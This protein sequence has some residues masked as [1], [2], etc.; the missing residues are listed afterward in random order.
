MDYFVPLLRSNTAFVPIYRSNLE[1]D[2]TT[3]G[4]GGINRGSG[5]VDYTTALLLGVS[6]PPAKVPAVPA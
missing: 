2:G 3:C 6:V 1:A 4:C 5:G